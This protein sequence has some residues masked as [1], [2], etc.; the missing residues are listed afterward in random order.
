ML[1]CSH[2]NRN[3]GLLRKNIFFDKGIRK[4]SYFQEVKLLAEKQV[5][6]IFPKK[7]LKEAEQTEIER[8]IFNF[9]NKV[10]D[11]FEMRR[12]DGRNTCE[13][14]AMLAKYCRLP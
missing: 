9:F 7:I 6:S 12:R 14:D 1:Y 13:F 11:I 10:R 3:S 5:N 2:T 8:H 4:S